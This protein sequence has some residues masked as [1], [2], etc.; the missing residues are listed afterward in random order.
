M[1]TI[2]T[3]DELSRAKHLRNRLEQAGVNADLVG[4]GA[5]Q[6]VTFLSRPHA[7]AKV[8]V[9]ENDFERAHA[10][11]LEWEKSDPAIG[12]VLRCPQCSSADIEYPQLTRKF[13][14]P[15]LASILFALKLF[16]REYYCQA[17]HYTWPPEDQR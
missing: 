3:F 15:A 6:R 9:E 4:E 17:C 2:A 14:T 13:L 7:N 5:L 1:R 8:D 11:L 10:L 12:P 16:P